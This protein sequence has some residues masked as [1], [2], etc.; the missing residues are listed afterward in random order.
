M[1][2]NAFLFNTLI[3]LFWFF[4][5]AC[6]STQSFAQEQGSKQNPDFFGGYFADGEYICVREP[7]FKI[8]AAWEVKPNTDRFNFKDWPHWLDIDRN[9][10]NEQEQIL[11]ETSLIPV[12]WENGDACGRVASGRWLIPYSGKETEDVYYMTMDH[13]I[14]LFE[15]HDMY[16]N[17][18]DE[19]KRVQFANSPMNLVP[20]D[21]P[22]KKAR[23]GRPSS[24]W[25]PPDK[26]YWCEYI[27]RRERV[28]RHFD[29]E[30]P[31]ADLIVG[32][33][34][35]HKFCKY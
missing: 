34:I 17:R 15:A 29:L 20:I 4:T 22:L 19:A 32:K 5:S 33:E 30:L 9:C 12:S 25:L 18:W 28:A 14:S 7:C 23:N 10:Q 24:K 11:A 16:G 21:W 13:V 6:I 1:A 26:N 3:S 35:K 31:K 8:H 2:K 27:L